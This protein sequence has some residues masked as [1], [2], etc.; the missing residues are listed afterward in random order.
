MSGET[1]GTGLE[2]GEKE[3]VWRNTGSRD[4][5]M[6]ERQCRCDGNADF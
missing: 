4:G 6:K 1:L 2:D 5:L 3:E